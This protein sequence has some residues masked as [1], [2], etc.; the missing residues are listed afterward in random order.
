MQDLTMQLNISVRENIVRF[1]FFIRENNRPGM[2][3][4]VDLD[5]VSDGVDFLE[6]IRE[7]NR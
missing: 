3:P 5:Y 1:L 6:F 2:V 4:S 7:K